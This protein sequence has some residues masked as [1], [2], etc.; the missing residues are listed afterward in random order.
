MRRARSIKAAAIGRLIAAFVALSILFAS[1]TAEDETAR[2][3]TITTAV[4]RMAALST[5][6]KDGVEDPE[7]VERDIRALMALAREQLRPVDDALKRAEDALA[8]LGAAPKEGEAEEAPAIA[9]ERATVNARISALRGQRTRVLALIDEGARALG[10]LS[11]RRFKDTWRHT[12]ARGAPLVLPSTWLKAAEDFRAFGS[13]LGQGASRWIE[14]RRAGG[15][16]LGLAGL[17]A[18]LVASFLMVGP[19]RAF[20]QQAFARRIETFQP[21]PRRRVAAAGVRMLTRL[22]PGIIGGL[23]VIESARALGLIAAD[24]IAVARAIWFALVAY[25]LVDGFATGLFSPT[26]PG[27]AL[28]P[29][30]AAKGKRVSTILVAIVLVV[31]AKE[32]LVEILRATTGGGAVVEV[33]TGV[34][35]LIVG[36]LFFRFCEK[37]FWVDAAPLAAEDAAPSPRASQDTWSVVRFAGRALAVVIMAAALAGHVNFADFVATRLYFL[38]L[39][40]AVA[41]FARAGLKEAAAWADR[42]L[43]AGRSSGAAAE[44]EAFALWIG[45]GVDATLALLLI[46]ALLVLAGAEWSAVRDLFLRAL[47]G[48]RVGGVVISLSD[49]FLAIAAFVGVLFLTRVVQGAV[50]RGPMAQSRIDSGIR[51]SLTTLLGYAGLVI[52]ALIALGVLGVNL[53]NFALIA[54]ALSVGIGFGLQSIVNNFVSGLILLFERPIKAGDWIVTTSGEGVVKKIGM[55]STELETFD[56][57]AIII[58]NSELVAASVTNWTHK[59]ALGRISVAVG[60]SYASDPD[61]VRD[62]LL[63]CARSHKLVV[64]Y[65]EPFVVWLDFGPS[66]L[67]FELR[68]F[69]ADIAR[70]LQ[71]RTELRFAIFKAFREKGIEMPFPQQDIYIRPVRAAPEVR[72]KSPPSAAAGTPPAGEPDAVDQPDDD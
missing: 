62:T 68:A 6:L 63:D 13:A 27:W 24:A 8:L 57:A 56:R 3:R 40:L 45:A 28:A 38:A 42:R 70:G 61:L 58:P 17:A 72:P 50:Q 34:A 55:R 30:D 23:I 18:A 35:A 29:I 26:A 66:A 36:A 60:A 4:E 9:Q 53:T 31:G 71:V 64:A 19:L 32:V 12:L 51:N 21:T 59:N 10:D 69:I 22:V 1:A 46:P 54:G 37:G 47:V 48:F 25:L 41:W 11:E 65:P 5:D 15:L 44:G 39:L 7:T 33:A 52:A 20:M 14:Q 49:I 2:E 16:A 67:S 43:R